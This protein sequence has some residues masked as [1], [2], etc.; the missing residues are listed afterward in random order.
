[1]VSKVQGKASGVVEAVL[2]ATWVYRVCFRTSTRNTTGGMYTLRYL[3]DIFLTLFLL[4]LFAM[5]KKK[6]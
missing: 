1:M 4:V 2:L 3:S 6:I 5:G